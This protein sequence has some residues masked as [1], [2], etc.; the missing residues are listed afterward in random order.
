MPRINDL[1]APEGPERTQRAEER[2]Q[3][4][5]ARSSTTA[6]QTQE[7]QTRLADTARDIPD[8]RQDRVAEARA[9]LESG[10]YDSESVRRVIA[11]RFLDQM[12]I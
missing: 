5:A 3:A 1:P 4:D 7:L 11:D 10:E 8:V 9:R 2:R 12:G 6:R